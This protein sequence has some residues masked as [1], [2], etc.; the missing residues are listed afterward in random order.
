MKPIYVINVL[1][2]IWVHE[3]MF[4]VLTPRVFLMLSYFALTFVQRLFNFAST[5]S[6]WVCYLL[7]A[8]CDA[9]DLGMVWQIITRHAFLQ[10]CFRPHCILGWA[11]CPVMHVR[12]DVR[13]FLL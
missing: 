4:Y 11:T 3:Y 8:T 9:E 7:K 1:F 12:D 2:I 5:V 10:C 13:M 6:S